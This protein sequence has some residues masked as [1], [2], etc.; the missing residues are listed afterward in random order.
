MDLRIGWREALIAG[1]ALSGILLAFISA[2]A[3]RKRATE[4]RARY[5]TSD[6]V[7]QRLGAIGAALG[8]AEGSLHL[9]L[10]THDRR[11]LAAYDAAR[12]EMRQ[13]GAAFRSN[14]G[15]PG[16]SPA[17]T[18][19]IADQIQRYLDLMAAAIE[20][21]RAPSQ[22]GSELRAR[23][24]SMGRQ[25]MANRRVHADQADS[26]S[27]RAIRNALAGG[28]L[29]F[30]SLLY[31]VFALSSS[32]SQSRR[33]LLRMQ[34]HDRRHELLAQRLEH[35]QEEERG[36]LARAIHDEFGQI[37]TAIKMDIGSAQRMP[38]AQDA[39][40]AA[41]LKQ[42]AALAEEGVRIARRMSME[43]RPAVLDH[44]G[45]LPALE[46]Q[47]R[48]FQR[49]T[50]IPCLCTAPA[51]QTRLPLAAELA[52]FRITQEALTNIARHARA[53]RVSIR[54]EASPEQTVLDIV[55]DGAGFDLALLDDY[56]S[57][58]LMGMQERA[59]A[60]GARCEFFSTPGA[61]TTVRT[62][63]PMGQPPA[64]EVRC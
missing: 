34:D 38:P 40:L 27:A 43:L 9:Y 2:A 19:G 44:M 28:A 46:W 8:E 61:G 58:G 5:Q 36:A 42:A 39:A 12:E 23:L 48:E 11:H 62:I 21:A 57:I 31:P 35:V 4:A 15:D 47:S 59:R 29:A 49:R 26:A 14:A 37:L 56:R 13:A 63:V 6:A 10:L 16:V 55:D 41:R 1:V 64:G 7:V 3:E 17:E 32:L 18:A 52:L 33:H 54:L 22:D 50:F 60:A 30:L 45:L 24:D 53:T 25:W 20:S 51:G